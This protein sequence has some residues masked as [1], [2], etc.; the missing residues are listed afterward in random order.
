MSIIRASFKLNPMRVPTDLSGKR[1]ALV[2]LSAIGDVV[3]GLPLVNSLRAAFNSIHLTWIIQPVPH[4][5]VRYHPAVDE[6][7]LFRRELGLR[8]YQEVWRATR[9]R[10]FDLVLAPHVYFKAGVITGLLR[11]PRKI[12]FDRSRTRDLNTLFTNERIPARPLGHVLEQNLEF[13]DYLGIP[14]RLEWDLGA[15]PAE[16]ERYGP[17]LPP[18]GQPTVAMVLAS[19]NV[20]KDWPAERYPMLVRRVQQELGARVVLVGGLSEP[21][22]AVARLL[23]EVLD[24][25][26]WDL[27]RLVYLLAQSDALVS[28]DTGPLHISVALGTPSVALMGYTNP[29]W[30]GPARFGELMVDAYADP[31]ERSVATREYRPGRMYRIGVEQV[32][33]KVRLA[34]TLPR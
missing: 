10:R 23:P 8:A 2:L 6:F 25:R 20:E 1:V 28:P 11:A 33:E 13:L 14:R 17:L 29:R 7:V 3:H 16:T 18:S 24:L 34:L 4:Q 32:L 19:S 5:L 31:G 26:A 12:G 30:M 21:E 27:R 9:D 15:T 22:N